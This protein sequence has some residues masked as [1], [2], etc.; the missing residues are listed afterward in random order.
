LSKN[1]VSQYSNQILTVFTVQWTLAAVG[2]DLAGTTINEVFIFA[3]G[4]YYALIQGGQIL[5]VDS[6]NM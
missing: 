6:L 5:T 1:I 4:K 3:F 2:G